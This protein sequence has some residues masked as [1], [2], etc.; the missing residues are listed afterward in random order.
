MGPI[1]GDT[2]DMR[3]AL[4]S[5]LHGNELAVDAVMRAAAAAGV[6]RLICLGDVATLGAHPREVIAR[7]RDAGC[8][9]ILGNH[10]EFMLEPELVHTYTEAPV[11]VDAVDWCRAELGDDDVA[12]L[13]G[14]VR[15]A[16]VDLGG[17]ARL[18]LYHGSP[19]SNVE[20]LLAT[21]PADALDRAL[22]GRTATV[23][24]GGH[25]HLAMMRQHRGTLVVNPGSVG[26]PFQEIPAGKP[27]IL[28]DHAEYAIVEAT[29][30]AISVTLCRVALDR[31]ALRAQASACDHPLR[32]MLEA[33]Y[34]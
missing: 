34:A 1:L 9:C 26:L 4:I 10:D 5:D 23:M 32:P 19:R 2:G 30:G 21:T 31:A 18:L 15:D 7:L 16:E 29:A 3:V 11:V 8:T 6:D 20:D 17:G 14:F 28:L 12:F 22:A 24:A 27:P 13:R 25:T 33:S